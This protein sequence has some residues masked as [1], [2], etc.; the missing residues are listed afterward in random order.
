MTDERREPEFDENISQACWRR[1]FWMM[2]LGLTALRLLIAGRFGLSVDES[3]YAMYARRLA[4]GYFDHPPMV[5]WLGALTTMFGESAWAYRLGP[6]LGALGSMWILRRLCLRLYPDRESLAFR[7]ILLLCCLPVIHLLSI[8]L[9]PDATLN[10]FWCWSLLMAWRA[11]Q[12]DRWQDWLGL[13]VCFGAAL[14][15]KYHAVLLPLVLLGFVL[16]VPRHRAQIFSPKPYVAGLVGLV[17]FLP[18]ILWN[19]QNGWVSY[20]FQLGHGS[21]AGRGGFAFS[22]VL[23]SVGGQVAAVTPILF[24]LL[25]W[26]YV[27][28]WRQARRTINSALPGAAADDNVVASPCAEADLFVLWSSAPVFLFFCGIGMFGKILPHWPAVGL[29]TGVL[30]LAVSWERAV[31][32]GHVRLQRAYMAGSLLAAA[33]TGIMYLLIFVPFVEPLHHR[34]RQITLDLNTRFPAIGVLREFEL[35]HDPVN[36]LFGWEE[37]A[38]AVRTLQQSMPD[39]ERTFIAVHR[40]FT[41]SQLG[42]H[43]DPATPLAQLHERTSQYSIWFDPQEH[44]GWDAVFVD[45][46]RYSSRIDRYVDRFDRVESD[47]LEVIGRRHGRPAQ[48]FRLYRCFGYRP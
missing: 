6:V 3:H 26:G 27:G 15:S 45:H 7:A 47:A 9:L 20:L 39:P 46:L 2:I 41:A 4:A 21:G 29:W 22:K 36:D 33:L 37:A 13:G 23:E 34:V 44:A 5:G 48:E 1:L 32:M 16:C 40:F 12:Q 31:A 43:L 24:V 28:L 30:V 35:K 14:L 38:E 42:V 11:L 25:L 18:N 17:V 8:A 10:L 19:A